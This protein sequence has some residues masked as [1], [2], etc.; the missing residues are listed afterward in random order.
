MNWTSI[1]SGDV[2]AAGSPEIIAAAEAKSPGA[3][4]EAIADAVA[5][6]RQAVSAGN[7]LD[8]DVTRV[9]NSLKRLTARR[10]FFALVDV[11]QAD[12]GTDQR[13]TKKNDQSRLNRLIDEKLR[14]EAPDNSAGHGEMQTQPS[15]SINPRQRNFT[16][17]TTD[18]I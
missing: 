8:V 11:L 14:V 4:V 6:V 16:D 5:E 17:R 18:G 12:L 3:T 15:P 7:A 1:T 9:P 2:N 13:E 10:A